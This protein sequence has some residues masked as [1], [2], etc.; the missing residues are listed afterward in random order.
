MLVSRK[1]KVDKVYD[2][3]FLKCDQK[4][5]KGL[6]AFSNKGVS[7]EPPFVLIIDQNTKTIDSRAR[8]V[9]KTINYS[10]RKIVSVSES[11]EKDIKGELVLD[12]YSGSY[13]WVIQFTKGRS[14]GAGYRMWGDCEKMQYKKKF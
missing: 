4:K 5:K 13:V 2:A 1:D 10:D 9:G 3:V 14:K 11:K 7:E 12:R 8:N 6:G